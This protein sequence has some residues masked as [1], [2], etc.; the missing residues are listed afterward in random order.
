[1]IESDQE[2]IA[3]L[4]RELAESK[5]EIAEAAN[6]LHDELHTGGHG[7]ETL[8]SIVSRA[9]SQYKARVSSTRS[10]K[11]WG[12]ES[13]YEEHGVTVQRIDLF[14]TEERAKRYQ[15]DCG[16]KITPL[17]AHPS[18]RN[19]LSGHRHHADPRDHPDRS[20]LLLCRPLLG[21]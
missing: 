18:A 16:G 6:T 9:V 15:T 14:D 21:A 1:M 3:R 2:K 13:E 7:G 10:P 4:E 19:A 8:R 5:T 20:R 12:V 11:A 17:Y